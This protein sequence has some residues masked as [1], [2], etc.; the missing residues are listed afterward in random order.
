MHLLSKQR[1]ILALNIVIA[2]R[3]LI[4]AFATV[5]PRFMADDFCDYD[6]FPQWGIPRT[7]IAYYLRWSGRIV[8]I[9]SIGVLRFV[10]AQ[11]QSLLAI[12]FLILWWLSIF[13]LVR[14]LA[15]RRELPRANMWAEL[16]RALVWPPASIESRM[17]TSA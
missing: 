2:V 9:A 8:H 4:Y 3:V 12:S 17:P 7:V 1:T 5:Y 6:T 10:P 16:G 15:T 11:A 13:L 14:L